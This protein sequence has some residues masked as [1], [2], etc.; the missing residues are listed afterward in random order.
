MSFKFRLT[1][2]PLIK[3]DPSHKFKNPIQDSPKAAETALTHAK[4]PLNQCLPSGY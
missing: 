1:S 3:Y 2:S 4:L